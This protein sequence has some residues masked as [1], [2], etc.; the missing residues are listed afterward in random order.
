MKR[1]EYSRP[2]LGNHTVGDG[3][4]VKSLLSYSK[5]GAA[6][7]PFLLLDYAGPVEFAPSEQQRGVDGH[8][9]RGFETVTIVYAGGLQH[10]DSAGNSGEIGP[11]DVQWMTAGSGVI[12]EELHSPSFS[13]TGGLFEIVQLWVNLPA[14]QKMADPRYQDLRASE[15]PYVRTTF[16]AVRVIA[17]SYGGVTGP[18]RTMT[19]LQ[20]L[21]MRLDAGSKVQVDIIDGHSATLVTLDAEVSVNGQYVGSS[22]TTVFS[23][24]GDQVEFSVEKSGKALLLTGQPIDE[25]IVGY[26]PFVMNSQAEIREAIMDYQAG[27]MGRLLAKSGR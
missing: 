9:H 6:A 14:S 4:P 22:S 12:H 18:A 11:G 23:H 10:R 8:P 25:P 1:V 19:D 16:G 24:L 2:S 17:G 5:D 3:F 27:R 13:S 7:S 15:I 20:V 26:G 21:D